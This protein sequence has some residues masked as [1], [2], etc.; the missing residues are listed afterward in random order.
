MDDDNVTRIYPAQSKAEP[1]VVHPSGMS[2]FEI[3]HAILAAS[4][5]IDVA[6]IT[7]ERLTRERVR[8]ALGR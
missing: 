8:R 4:A 1:P 3:D 5:R 2:D 6:R 7:I